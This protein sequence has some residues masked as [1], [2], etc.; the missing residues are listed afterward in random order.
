MKS[1][2]FSDK[3]YVY[4]MGGEIIELPKGSTIVDF[5]YKIDSELGNTLVGAFVNDKYVDVNYELKNKDRVKVLTDDLSYGP[6]EEWL[7]VAKTTYARR[8]IRE[9]QR[10][11]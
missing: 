6:R 8:M 3:I 5:A 2:L 7:N 4:T 10:R 9:F 11:I 1:E